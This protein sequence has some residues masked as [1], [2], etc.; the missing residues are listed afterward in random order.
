MTPVPVLSDPIFEVIYG[1][2]QGSYMPGVIFEVISEGV[3]IRGQI[4]GHIRGH[5]KISPPIVIIEIFQSGLLSIP[6][7]GISKYSSFG[8]ME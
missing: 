6:H 4:R 3:Q 7:A 1:L 5:I 2:F 8:K